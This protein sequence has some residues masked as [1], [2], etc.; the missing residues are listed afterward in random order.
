ML[1]LAPA[2][3]PPYTICAPIPTRR[4]RARAYHAESL[5]I[6][7]VLAEPG[8]LGATG[9]SPDL[10]G[11]DVAGAGDATRDRVEQRCA[12]AL[13]QTDAAFRLLVQSVKDYA[14]LLLDPLG[15]VTSWNEGAER[16]EGYA[17]REILGRSF[18]V[19]YPA[20]AIA[21]GLPQ[22]QLDAASREGRFEDEG[23]R[24]RKDG[25]HFWANVV[26]TALR[27]GDGRLVGFAKV[28]R[29]LS[30]RREDEEVRRVLADERAARDQAEHAIRLRDEVLA[31]VAHDLRNPL[32]AIA[33]SAM[34]L[35][36]HP[37]DERHARQ[38]GI[39]RRSATAMDH[40]IRDLLDVTRIE[41]G[42]F[43]VRRAPV[44]IGAILDE[45]YGLFETQARSRDIALTCGSPPDLPPAIGD[46]ERLVQVLSNLVGNALKFSR[47]HGRICVRARRAGAYIEISVEDSGSG[48][49]PEHLAHVFDRFWRAEQT[50]GSGAGLGLAIAKGIVEAHDGEIRVESSAAGTRVSFT[51]PCAS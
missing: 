20:D 37:L 8:L 33:I 10:R 23:W 22:H 46:G 3:S 49:A 31:I 9:G 40:L 50:S 47:S 51:V 15:H 27:D 28:T 36:R 48:I 17:A 24:V 4:S 42:S 26:I 34:M 13:P 41:A 25:S 19:F 1:T 6:S 29:D 45:I 14:V 39:I 44:E 30:A 16:L 35:E 7:N 5:V 2:A 11:P 18:T 12:E 21:A 32:N 43:V 38:V